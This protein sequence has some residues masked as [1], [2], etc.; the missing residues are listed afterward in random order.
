MITIN[1]IPYRDK[2]KKDNLKRQIMIISSAFILF[3]AVLVSVHLWMSFSLGKLESKAAEADA[4]LK[5]LN[6]QVGDV[7]KFKKDKKQLE[8]KLA[9]IH[10]LEVNRSFPVRLL[11]GLNMLVPSKQL[12]L[13]KLAQKRGEITIEGTAK[14]SGVVA[15]FMKSLEKAPFFS[16][17]DL[18]VTREKEVVGVKLQQFIVVCGLN[19]KGE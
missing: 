5:I 4:R 10:S 3:I 9:V 13:E 1:L 8:Q 15:Q 14:D 18:L 2:E 12:W 6:K 11:D 17:V 7:E 16:S 19:G